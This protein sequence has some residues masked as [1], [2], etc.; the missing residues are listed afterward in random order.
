MKLWKSAILLLVTLQL[1]SLGFASSAKGKDIPKPSGNSNVN[2]PASHWDGS[3]I[4]L[5]L[6][7]TTGNTSTKSLTSSTIAKYTR[8]RW[9]NTATVQLWNSEENGTT[10]KRKF[11]LQNQANY[12]FNANKTN[13]IFLNANDTIDHFSPY[14]YQLVALGGY[15]RTL[16]QN[17]KVTLAAQVGPGWR[18]NKERG[19]GK[20]TNNFVVSPQVDFDWKMTKNTTFSQNVRYD[21]GN[22]YNY[23][24]AESSL[25]NKLMGNL[26]IAVNFILENYSKIPAGSS[27]KIKTDTTTNIALVYT[28]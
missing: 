8:E 9:Q 21:L 11:F 16:V 12:Y 27:R 23:L 3:N 2:A 14:Q 5:G 6:N 25:T 4:S 7:M 17:D 10:T 1:P 15:G 28:F 24:R 13:F 19:T 18:R 26:A 22:P 20:T